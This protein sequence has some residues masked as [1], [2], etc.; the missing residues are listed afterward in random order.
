MK[1]TQVELDGLRKIILGTS[2]KLLNRFR[3]NNNDL[4]ININYDI[5]FI[6]DSMIEYFDTNT[7]FPNLKVLNRGIAGATTKLISDN[8]DLIFYNILAKEIYLSIGSNDLVLLEASVEETTLNIISLINQIKKKYPNTKINYLSTTPV[9]NEDH[10]R[11][12]KIYVAGR[13]NDELKA[14]N[15]SIKLFSLNNNV[16]FINVYD[17]LTN[18]LGYIDEKYTNDGIHLNKVGYEVYISQ[19]K[20]NK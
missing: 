4:E 15:N 5:L 14:I 2:T 12:K 19:I 3:I 9:I 13:K 16:N 18:D 8:F 17:S 20:L 11:Y 6:G 10:K 7:N 1:L